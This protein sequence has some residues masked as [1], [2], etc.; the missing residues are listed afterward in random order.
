MSVTSGPRPAMSL[1]DQVR[2]LVDRAEI[3]DLICAYARTIDSKDWEGFARLFTEGGVL[4]MPW[5]GEGAGVSGAALLA[6]F[7]SDALGRFHQTQHILTNHQIRIHGDQA[8]STH[9]LHSS[10]VRSPDDPQ[11]HWDVGGWYHADYART[12]DGWRFTRVALDAVWQS[13]GTGDLDGDR[14]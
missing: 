6:Q 12:P 10:H 1:E 13:G 3:E 8:T 14:F 4:A 5:E 2:W 11:D 9:Y 7:S